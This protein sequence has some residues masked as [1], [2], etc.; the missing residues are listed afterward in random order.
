MKLINALPLCLTIIALLFNPTKTPAEDTPATSSIRYTTVNQWNID[1]TPVDLTYS[2]D[3]N[4]VYILTDKQQV[5]AYSAQ[6]TLLGS[7][8]VK[9][10]VSSIGSAPYG[11][12]LYLVDKEKKTFTT[13]SI[14]FK[15]DI[16]DGKS[17]V[18]GPDNA[19][20]TITLFTDFECP[21]CKSVEPLLNEVLEKNSQTTKLV[22]KNFPLQFHKFADK[23]ARAALAART[24]GKFWEFHDA[25]FASKKLDDTVIEDIAKKLNLDLEQWKAD[26]KSPEIAAQIADDVKTARALKVSGTPTFFINGW[27]LKNRSL[28]GFQELIDLELK[29]N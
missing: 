4:Y 28:Q 17:P 14:D 10:G 22:F 27:L 23:S 24:Q 25:L 8:P 1:G 19:P 29:K 16:A 13:T 2:L 7:I 12:L 6:G 11:E 20:V 9:S 18:K 5:L 26:M 3:K 15:Q 21:Y